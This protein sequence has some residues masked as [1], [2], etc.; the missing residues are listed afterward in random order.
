ME[1]NCLKATF[2]IIHLKFNNSASGKHKYWEAVQ[3]TM[4][5][6]QDF[7]HQANAQIQLMYYASIGHNFDTSEEEIISI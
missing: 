3:R 4:L 6:M 5:E 1:W 7:I 2:K